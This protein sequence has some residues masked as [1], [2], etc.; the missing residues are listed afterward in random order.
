MARDPDG[1]GEHVMLLVGELVEALRLRSQLADPPF[2]LFDDQLQILVGPHGIARECR[3]QRFHQAHELRRRHPLL[4][5]LL[6]R[7]ILGEVADQVFVVPQFFQLV[8]LF[9]HQLVHGERPLLV[10]RRGALEQERHLGQLFLGQ[11]VDHLEERLQ[12]GVG[13][14]VPDVARLAELRRLL[15]AARQ[16]SAN[17]QQQQGQRATHKIGIYTETH[18]NDRPTNAA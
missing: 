11:F 16:Q 5:G 1:R 15:P 13:H 17:G 12:V 8:R 14:L 2:A 7:P 4:Q 18:E 6:Q 3:T 9:P 10:P